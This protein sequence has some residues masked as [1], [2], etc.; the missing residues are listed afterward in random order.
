MSDSPYREL[1]YEVDE[2]VATITLNRPDRLNALTTRLLSEIEHAF[3]AAEQDRRVVGI[4]LTGAGRGFSA[5][6]DMDLLDSLASGEGEG[7]QDV[8]RSD[9]GAR[10]LGEDFDVREFHDVVLRNGAL[11][12]S[13][14]RRQVESWLDSK[15]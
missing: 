8:L 1:I 11:P 9:P 5:G 10:A 13:I 15:S 3:A 6:A 7:D 4:V 14:L 2:P 12:L